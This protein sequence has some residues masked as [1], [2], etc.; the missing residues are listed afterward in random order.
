MKKLYLIAILLVSNIVFAKEKQEN[1]LFLNR[2][3]YAPTT[4]S[5]DEINKLGYKNWINQQIENP[6]KYNDSLVLEKIKDLD[7]EKKTNFEI[8]KINDGYL[9]RNN[10]PSE[11]YPNGVLYQNLK[12]KYIY[13]IYSENRLREMMVWF[14][15]NHFYVNGLSNQASLSLLNDYI[16]KIRD[17]SLTNFPD[18]LRM[19]AT[20]PA[21]LRFLNNS[22]N[23]FPKSKIPEILNKEKRVPEELAELK[24]LTSYGY[25]ENYARE[26]LE[27]HSLGVNS[28]YT[29][30]DIENLAR[31]LTGFGMADFYTINRYVDLKSLKNSDLKKI[32]EIYKNQYGA[33]VNEHLFVFNKNHHDFGEKVFLGKKIK[34]SGFGELNE[35][36]DMVSK[37]EKTAEFISKKM[38][39]Y[40]LGEEFN[41]KLIISLK[42]IYLQT[43]GDIKKMLRFIL[44]SNE[45]KESVV[46]Q[47]KYKD[48][49]SSYIYMYKVIIDNQDV[50]DFKFITDKLNE[51]NLGLFEKKTPEGYSLNGKDYIGSQILFKNLRFSKGVV[52]FREDVFK[53][54][55]DINY[56]LISKINNT[57]KSEN[58]L[59]FYFVSPYAARK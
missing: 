24:L 20:H 47:D 2:I 45:F 41:Q 23:I 36:I 25:N 52:F 10:V 22:E 58:A 4:K 43:N 12:K 39:T 56:D 28:G 34:G 48:V 8:Y 30:K 13:D 26:F 15:F 44:N 9:N 59:Y 49:Y 38:A 40:F 50:K 7:I 53:K 3:G 33:E 21:M 57:I 37:H 29:Q 54:K 31:I 16:N 19:T 1:I 51:L 46:R 32:K 11:G 42:D 6:N 14:W 35:V 5:L 27:L 18:L 55:L 17:L